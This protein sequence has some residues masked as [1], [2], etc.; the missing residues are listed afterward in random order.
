MSKDTLGDRMKRYEAAAATVLP[1]RMPVIIRVDGHGF[2]RWTKGLARPFDIDFVEAMNR[3]AIKLCK[4]IDGAV[5]AYIQSDEISVLIHNY[6]TLDSEPW[7]GNRVQKIVTI[8][9]ANASSNMTMESVNLFPSIKETEF[10]GRAWVLPEA[11]VCNYMLWRQQDATRN[12]VQMLAR[13]LYSH[14]E[15]DRKKN[16][17]LQEMCFQKG[18]NWN[19]MPTFFK[20]GRCVLRVEK[21]VG[22]TIRHVWEV[23]NEIPIFS[24][25]RDYVEKHLVCE[26][27]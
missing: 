1:I 14:K 26:E 3:V 23:D 12:S 25:D 24:R 22:N 15:C 2:H 7:F 20:R 5:L 16:A 6:K 4:K 11:D 8:A 17:A 19:D 18:T 13:T 27:E 10:D 21:A 9:A